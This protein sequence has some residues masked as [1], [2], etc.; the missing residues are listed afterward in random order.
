MNFL[1]STA[2]AALVVGTLFV[3]PIA[4]R[5]AN[6]NGTNQNGTNQNGNP[7]NVPAAPEVNPAGAVAV[8]TLLAGATLLLSARRRKTHS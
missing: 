7:Q 2:C 8:I 5:G 3:L 1:R 4:A 6:P